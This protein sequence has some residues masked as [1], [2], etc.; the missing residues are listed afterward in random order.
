M[1]RERAASGPLV[2]LVSVMVALTGCA[3]T[4]SYD[5]QAALQVSLQPNVVEGLSLGRLDAQGREERASLR[6]GALLLVNGVPVT[7]LGADPMAETVHMVLED[8]VVSVIPYE[9]VNQIVDLKDGVKWAEG[10]R[11]HQGMG[12][13]IGA[14]VGAVLAGAL[15]GYLWNEPNASGDGQATVIWLA[16][17][18]LGAGVLGGGGL[19]YLTGP[20]RVPRVARVTGDLQSKRE[21][22]V[23]SRRRGWQILGPAEIAELKPLPNPTYEHTPIPTEELPPEL[24]S[25]RDG[26]LV[27]VEFDRLIPDDPVCGERRRGQ[28]PLPSGCRCLEATDCAAGLCER[29]TEVMAPEGRC[30]SRCDPRCPSPLVCVANGKDTQGTCG[31]RPSP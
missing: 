20:A 1:Q 23:L 8:G 24:S 21:P 28:R 10:R 27:T 22:R 9:G 2:S 14:A 26:G 18:V 15:L 13:A 12:A 29:V 3:S 7:L 25:L 30:A 31:P 4:S 19:G 6:R 17:F 11:Q 16:P 5:R